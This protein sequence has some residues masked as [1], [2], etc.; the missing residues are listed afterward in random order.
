MKE[1]AFGKNHKGNTKIGT[2]NFYGSREE[3]MKA[4]DGLEND[5]ST[6]V[7]ESK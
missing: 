1:A 5:V 6:S 4:V 3:L 2:A 7:G